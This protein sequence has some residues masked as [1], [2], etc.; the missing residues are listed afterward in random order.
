MSYNGFVNYATWCAKLWL[1]ND[2]EE[3]KYWTEMARRY[4]D[5]YELANQLEEHFTEAM[6]D[7][8]NGLFTDLMQSAFDQIDWLEVA[9]SLLED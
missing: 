3:Y 6:P 7:V 4:P 5:P 8:D 2:Y 9:E 1:D